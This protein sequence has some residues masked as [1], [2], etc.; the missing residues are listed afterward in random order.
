MA[1]P[2]LGQITMFG[3]GFPPKG[4]AACNGQILP[5]N[6]NQAL[7]SLLSTQYGGDG[8]VNFALPDLRGRAPA[9]QGSDQIIGQRGGEEGHALTVAEMPAHAHQIMASSLDGNS[10]LPQGNV[11]AR[12]TSQVYASPN[13]SLTPTNVASLTGSNQPHTNM[14]PS[15]T[16]NFCIALVGIFPSRD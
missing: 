13:G 9:H 14:Q 3:F 16:L 5:I 8:R 15:L 7:F 4:W 2:F 11:L 6:Q 1:E 10:P 12:T